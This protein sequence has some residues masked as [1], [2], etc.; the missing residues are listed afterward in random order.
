M[1]SSN[2]I[3][4][5]LRS[6]QRTSSNLLRMLQGVQTWDIR[7]DKAST[8]KPMAGHFTNTFHYTNGHLQFGQDWSKWNHNDLK[9]IWG[10]SAAVWCT[11]S[12][13]SVSSALLA[14][15]SALPGAHLDGWPLYTIQSCSY[16]D[17]EQQTA[18][19]DASS[20][21]LT[22]WSQWTKRELLQLSLSK[23]SSLPW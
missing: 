11:R 15:E 9:T 10:F 6:R 5:H 12:S 1:V 20:S 19:L 16:S 18:F 13:V 17:L 22:H 3:A 4:T 23:Y 7:T 14:P 21:P 8:W 2:S